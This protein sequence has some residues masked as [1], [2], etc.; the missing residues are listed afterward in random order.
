MSLNWSCTSTV[1]LTITIKPGII[2]SVG[3]LSFN[4]QR[5]INFTLVSCAETIV[6]RKPYQSISV[7]NATI[8][9]CMRQSLVCSVSSVSHLPF[10]TVSPDSRV[11]YKR[12][13]IDLQPSL[14]IWG[15]TYDFDISNMSGKDR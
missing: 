13:D 10:T 3:L 12:R 7:S 9:R 6:A 5:F 2:V 15:G 8:S 1:M 4:M 11:C 14:I